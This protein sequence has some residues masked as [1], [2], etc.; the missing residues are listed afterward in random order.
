M[1]AMKLQLE[2]QGHEAAHAV[3]VPPQA[4][5]GLPEALASCSPFAG[6]VKQLHGDGLW[7]GRAFRAWGLRGPL[8]GLCPAGEDC[9]QAP[10][11]LRQRRGRLPSEHG[12][13]HR[14]GNMD[15][16]WRSGPWCLLRSCRAL[17]QDQSI[18]RM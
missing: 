8:P 2:H 6:H 15:P 17:V 9:L 14:V 18:G 4:G 12:G 5:Q 11:G 13:P 16:G 7:V 1:R 10:W 3:S